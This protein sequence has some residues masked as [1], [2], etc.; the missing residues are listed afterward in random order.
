MN[1]EQIVQRVIGMDAH[2]DSFT[3]AILT[4]PTPAAA[5]IEKQFDKVPIDRLCSWATKHTSADDLIVLEASGN[6][7]HIVRRL[8][9][10][11]RK[12]IVLESCQV[13]KLKEAHANNDKLS[14]VRI[15]KA[16]LAGTA[17]EVWVPDEKTQER[18]DLWHAHRKAV[19]RCS[20]MRSR[21]K[22]YLSDNG[23]R[24]KRGTR[25]A[26]DKMAE[27]QIRSLKPWSR[28]QWGLI[29][30]M[31]QELR[32]ADEQRR[33]LRSLI[34]EDVLGNPDALVLTRLCGIR[35]LVAFGIIAI[36]GDIRRFVEP[37]K[38]VSYI[39]LNPAFESSGN[40]SW[41]GGVG[42]HGRKDLR[43]LMI[44]AAQS[45]MRCGKTP[46][47][48]WGRRLLRRKGD[49]GAN[50]A[51]AAVARK[52][53]VMVWYS[54]MGRTSPP[55]QIDHAMKLK[56][57]KM[58][59][60]LGRDGLERLGKK[61]AALRKEIIESMAFQRVYVLDPNRKYEPAIQGSKQQSSDGN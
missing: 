3:A 40:S 48:Q 8:A 37:A 53:V 13:G 6:S 31:L 39:G 29:E 23:V 26:E 56:V 1:K 12:A 27:E 10:V 16:Y 34:A 46:L 19:K 14:A 60:A 24:L 20:Q 35:E 36:V 32:Q 44:E 58:I 43:S 33:R 9:G 61:R 5:V 51:V 21:I 30:G 54:L 22:S 15:G 47:A 2:P 11:G 25:L 45:I 55:E 28:L 18:R 59:S 38:L 49:K 57:G 42:K 52:L 17:K 50:L 4:G 41:T 7:F